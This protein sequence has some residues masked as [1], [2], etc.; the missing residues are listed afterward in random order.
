MQTVSNRPI[1]ATRFEALDW[2]AAYVFCS[3]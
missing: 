1:L 3:G 2:T